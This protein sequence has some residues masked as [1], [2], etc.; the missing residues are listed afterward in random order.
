M[1]RKLIG[2][3]VA[4]GALLLG[5]AASAQ[6][7]LSFNYTDTS[8]NI[9]AN[10]TLTVVN[11]E[12]ISATGT[13]TSSVLSGT[14]SLVLVNAATVFGAGQGSQGIA[15]PSG[16]CT[17]AS[18]FTWQA[19]PGSGGGNLQADTVVY[20]NGN[21][22][23]FDSSGI[24][25]GIKNASGTF[26]GGLN[27]W[28]AGTAYQDGFAGAGLVNYGN[29]GILTVASVPEVDAWALMLTG[30]ALTGLAARRRRR[31]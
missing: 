1:E 24:L 31:P 11:G 7:V 23:Y 12:A 29:N 9:D 18:C 4:L 10:F 13:I 17:D 28:G 25:L 5:G 26:V 20:V 14:D 16:S 2:W 3:L 6:S 8:G 15:G 30:M 19:V 21:P 22:Q 27:I